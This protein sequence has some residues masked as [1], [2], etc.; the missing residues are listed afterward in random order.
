[1]TQIKKLG[2]GAFAAALFAVMAFAT[3]VNTAYADV[4][5]VTLSDSTIQINQTVDVVVV[6]DTAMDE[7]EEL[8]L[9][10]SG[11][12]TAK[13]DISGNSE[14]VCE[15]TAVVDDTT[16]TASFDCGGTT[17]AATSVT[18]TDG[19]TI[20]AATL[21]LKLTATASGT[22]IVLA[23]QET[24]PLVQS[25]TAFV[26]QST[27]SGSATDLTVT[28]PASLAA[29]GS[30]ITVKAVNASG[31]AV[32][33]VTIHADVTGGTCSV[34]TGSATPATNA[35]CAGT[36]QAN[37]NVVFNVD[38]SSTATSVTVNFFTG[39]GSIV[40][41]DLVETV[42]AVPV[43][44]TATAVEVTA[45]ATVGIGAT[46][47]VTVAVTGANGVP[48][49][50]G[51]S[52]SVVATAGSVVGCSD[53]STTKNGQ[54]TCT[55]VAPGSAQTV[56]ITAVSGS[57]VDTATVSVSGTGTTPTPGTGDGSFASAPNFGTGNVGSAVF[58][59]G[60]I[61][62]LADAVTDAGGTAVWVQGTDG[63]W[64]RYNTL[65]TGA[66]AFVNNAFNA[67]FSAGFTGSVAVFVVK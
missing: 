55:F 44:G 33:G 36:S 26:L 43:A 64:Y 58:N 1:M 65:A 51:T 61:A 50:E 25:A 6:L 57:L 46:S 62:D 20:S 23:Q 27:A 24:T 66:T 40:A 53:S 52:V 37:G 8:T 13:F 42:S 9:A 38:P 16:D 54:V 15:L 29:T 18:A 48:V 31:A 49:A 34:A 19:D 7:T 28:A 21:T 2:F 22:L 59:G 30:N 10:L 35:E 47:T 60:S 3:L 63:N 12:G 17:V 11:T 32:S 56:V 39:T 45:P 67:Q 14:L 41:G 4:D 5:T